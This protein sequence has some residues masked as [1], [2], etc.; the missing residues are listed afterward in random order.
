MIA[1]IYARKSTG[2]HVAEDDKSVTRQVENAKAFAV[3]RGWTVDDRYVFID[4]GVSGAETKKLLKKQ[5]LL[6]AI[7]NAPPFGVL[8]MQAQDRFSRRG[9]AE[10]HIELK[11]IARAGVT[12][13]F[14]ADKS[15]FEHGTFSSETLG[16]L[17]GEFAAEFRRNIA[18]KTHEAMLRQARPRDRRKSVRLRQR[19]HERPRGTSHQQDRSEGR[20]GDLPALRRR[21]GLQT[22][23][24]HAEREE[25]AVT[26]SATWPTRWMGPGHRARRA[27][28]FPVSGRDR[29]Q[30]DQETG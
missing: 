18:A 26:T 12:I 22:D 24:P 29:L 4:D 25:T 28:T 2:Q 10:A 21:G 1:A 15:R 19:A 16:F 3:E 5:L 6:D 7:K 13:W 11:A 8:I 17:K 27:Q 23:R 14:Y 9:G 20:P 30:P